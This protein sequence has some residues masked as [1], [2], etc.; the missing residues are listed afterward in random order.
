MRYSHQVFDKGNGTRHLCNYALV[1]KC[2]GTL[3]IWQ[4]Q[5]TCGANGHFTRARVW[6]GTL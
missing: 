1:F 6:Q 4:W 5:G 2:K 3:D